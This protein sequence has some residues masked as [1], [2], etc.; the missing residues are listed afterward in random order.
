M[1]QT[2]RNTCRSKPR[3]LSR[4]DQNFMGDGALLKFSSVQKARAKREGAGSTKGN[5]DFVRETDKAAAMSSTPGGVPFK[6][7]SVSSIPRLLGSIVASSAADTLP[8]EED[9]TQLRK[10]VDDFYTATRKQANRYQRDLETLS[11]RHGTA[12]QAR[13]RDIQKNN[14]AQTAAAATKHDDGIQ[15]PCQRALRSSKYI[16]KVC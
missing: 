2:Q 13:R 5:K 10:E 11:S 6:E 1:M 15:L 3:S 8:S 16:D 12:D 4:L 7:H 9:I 14:A